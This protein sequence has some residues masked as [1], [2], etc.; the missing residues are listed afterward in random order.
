MHSEIRQVG[1]SK[2]IILPK[3]ILEQ[4][5]FEHMVDM[6]V[7]EGGLIIRPLHEKRAG[8]KE[9]FLKAEPESDALNQEWQSFSNNLDDE[10]WAW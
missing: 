10:D 4:C 8:W 6:Q 2:G 5:H 7:V 9:A 1:N 3:A